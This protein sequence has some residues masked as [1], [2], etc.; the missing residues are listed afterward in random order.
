MGENLQLNQSQSPI[1]S[2]NIY[3]GITTDP[4]LPVHDIA[5]NWSSEAGPY[6]GPADNPVASR[7]L[8]KN[9]ANNNWQILGNA[10]AELD[11]LK[12]FIL[13]SS[14]GGHLISTIIIIMLTG[15]M[16]PPWYR[17]IHREHRLYMVVD[18]DQYPELF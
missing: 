8:A 14:F 2:P 10:Y 13:R 11:F 3:G 16:I 12:H 1:P 15:A 18:M 6:A 4:W 9:D 5:G 17:Q 7:E